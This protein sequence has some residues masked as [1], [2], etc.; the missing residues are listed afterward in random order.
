MARVHRLGPIWASGGLF[1]T[2]SFSKLQKLGPL[3]PDAYWHCFA[4]RDGDLGRQSA[5]TF[6]S[7]NALLYTTFDPEG[8]CEGHPH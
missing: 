3:N 4:W 2:I 8:N 6:D 5:L 7:Y 1:D